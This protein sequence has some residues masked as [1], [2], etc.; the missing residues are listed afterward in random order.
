[1]KT[2]ERVS[3][4]IGIFGFAVATIYG[5]WSEWGEPVGTVGLYFAGLLGFMIAGYLN[6]THRKLDRDPSDNPRAM[7]ED[8]QGDYGFFSP[9]SW[10]P[11]FLAGS[12]AIVFLGLA[13]G[14]W[15]FA[16]GVFLV[17]PALVYWAFEYWRGPH[18]L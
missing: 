13:V 6:V 16:I 17:V 8:I 10:S 3:T 4:I 2:M 12:A 15:V 1:M 7:V 14:W 9:H 5:L 11:L 18:A